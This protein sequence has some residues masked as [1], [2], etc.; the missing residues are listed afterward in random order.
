MTMKYAIMTILAVTIATV[1][2]SPIKAAHDLDENHPFTS[3]AGGGTQSIC[4]DVTQMNTV[5]VDGSTNQSQKIID[6]SV[7][8]IAEFDDETDMTVTHD[9]QCNSG[10]N[11]V[12]AAI[13]S[14]GI[15]VELD[16]NAGADNQ[17]SC[18][19]LEKNQDFSTTSNCGFAQDP[20]V[21]LVIMHEFGHFAGLD[22][23]PWYTSESHTL[24]SVWCNSNWT[25]LKADDKTQIN[26]FY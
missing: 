1:N 17:Y 16:Y 14:T 20:D 11:K 6:A 22:H 23:A 15:A 26:G 2:A 21:D 25:G 10:D 8:A 4:F 12:G 24:M 5:D 13:L 7:D 9:S 3:G 18:I 19:A